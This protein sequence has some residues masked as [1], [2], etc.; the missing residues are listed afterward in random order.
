MLCRS[1]TDGRPAKATK[2]KITPQKQR[3]EIVH[4]RK[5]SLSNSVSSADS[6]STVQSSSP[7]SSTSS[8]F[9]SPRSVKRHTRVLEHD[10]LNLHPPFVA[11][12]RLNER[13]FIM[14][15]NDHCER[16]RDAEQEETHEAYHLAAEEAAPTKDTDDSVPPL[17]SPTPM[18]HQL[19]TNHERKQAATRSTE[20]GDYF[21]YKLGLV[22]QHERQ[23]REA[24][25]AADA[26]PLSGSS[27]RPVLPRSHWSESTIQTLDMSG[28]PV[29]EDD[30][31][32]DEEAEDE[33]YDEDDEDEDDVDLSA[34]EMV[35]PEPSRAVSWQ[36]YDSSRKRRSAS[37]PSISASPRRPPMKSLDSVEEFIK[38]GGWKRRGIVFNDEKST[39]AEEDGL[40]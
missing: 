38:R 2:L 33:D 23:Q 18:Q 6:S 7:S 11:P 12:P 26:R 9:S 36:N 13:L 40:F 37:S 32:E 20:G 16:L 22:Q 35:R 28:T 27:S 25:A 3:P 1:P 24:M 14:P 29:V 34:F 19:A 4:V 5:P 17:D 39:T 8:T 10:P 30:D 21:L 15:Q 31:D